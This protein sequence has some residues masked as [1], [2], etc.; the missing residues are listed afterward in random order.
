MWIY[1]QIEESFSE[2]EEIIHNELPKE[3]HAVVEQETNVIRHGNEPKEEARQS[4]VQNTW[5][6]VEKIPKLS[7]TH[8]Y[9]YSY[10][11]ICE[12]Y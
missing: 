12:I 11:K 2:T 8:I 3:A 10:P 5:E 1:F 6:T 7:S 9:S 4:T